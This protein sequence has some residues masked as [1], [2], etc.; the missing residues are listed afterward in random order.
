MANIRLGAFDMRPCCTLKSTCECFNPIMD[1]Q[2]VDHTYARPAE[3]TL[4]VMNP[5][6]ILTLYIQLQNCCLQKTR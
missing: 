5:S 1:A 4:C 3:L 6:Q 2:M